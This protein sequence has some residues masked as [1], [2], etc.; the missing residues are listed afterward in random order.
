MSEPFF[1]FKTHPLDRNACATRTE[2]LGEALNRLHDLF[3]VSASLPLFAGDPDEVQ[4]GTAVVTVRMPK[5]L[6][7][8]LKLQA[9]ANKCSLNQ[10]CLYKLCIAGQISLPRKASQ[11]S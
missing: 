4:V 5:Q 9:A 7:E 11:I 6:H 8:Q 1:N 2:E 10:L 3:F